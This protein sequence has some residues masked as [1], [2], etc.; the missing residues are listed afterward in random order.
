MDPQQQLKRNI[1]RQA[2]RIKKAERE[3][4]SLLSS[5]IYLGTIGLLFVVPIVA[6]AYLGHWLDVRGG[7]YSAHWILPC[8]LLGIVV[9]AV[10][11]FLFMWSNRDD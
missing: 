9:G 7:E 3:R 2:R 10:N 5:T 1:Q 4:D 8:L 11:V 6:G